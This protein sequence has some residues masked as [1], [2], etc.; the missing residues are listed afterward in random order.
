MSRNINNIAVW[1]TVN[2]FLKESQ[3]TSDVNP[4]YSEVL[5]FFD[6]EVEKLEKESRENYLDLQEDS[7][8]DYHC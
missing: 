1:R 4:T 3:E 2:H 7:S 6:L 5:E 8:G